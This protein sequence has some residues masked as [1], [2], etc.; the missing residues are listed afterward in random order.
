MVMEGGITTER[1]GGRARSISILRIA[2]PTAYRSIRRYVGGNAPGHG[3]RGYVGPRAGAFARLTVNGTSEQDLDEAAR[4]FAHAVVVG[5]VDVIT[6]ILL[7]KS[8]KEVRA[9]PSW[10]PSNPGLIDAGPPPAARGPFF[11]PRISRPIRL[12]NGSLGQTDWYGNIWVTR[13][14]V[15]GEQRVT[16]YHELVHSWL[17]PKFRLFRHLRAS[18]RASAYV[19]SALLRY[20]EEALAEGFGQLKVNGFA[21]ATKAITFP[22]GKNGINGYVT[23]SQLAAEGHA[24]GSIILGGYM[25]RVFITLRPPAGLAAPQ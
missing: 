10:R 24:I 20:L 19:R 4:R 11:K 17:S 9:R 7:H 5:G 13:D 14:Q 8:M 3:R 1:A 2:T 16:L 25:F 6:A 15:L 18:V 22:L 23:I 12:P 21:A